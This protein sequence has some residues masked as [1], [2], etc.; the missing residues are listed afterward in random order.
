M[1]PLGPFLA[2]NFATS[3]SPWMVTPQ[4]LAPFRIPVPTRPDGDPA[5]LPYLNDPQNQKDGAF[6][7]KLS[8]SMATQKMRDEDVSPEPIIWSNM[9]YLYWT[10][11]QLLTHHS[12]SG[13][14]LA[15][16]DVLGTGTISGPTDAELGSLL[17]L[18]ANGAQPVSLEN[19]EARSYLE[20]GDEIL[21]RGRCEKTGFASIGFGDCR[22]TIL[23]APKVNI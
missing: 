15:S 1:I 5:P 4:A 21:L 3:V 13:C 18:T 22:G 11:A 23:P 9:K 19:G 16:G 20:D 2:K 8:V 10:P 12:I 6:D 14:S 17:E 7:V